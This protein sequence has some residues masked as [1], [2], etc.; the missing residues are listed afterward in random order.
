MLAGEEG[1][2]RG[3]DDAGGFDVGSGGAEAGGEGGGDPVAALAGV[4]TH[5]DADVVAEGGGEGDADCVDGALV[6]RGFTG[7]RSYS[8][9][10][11]QLPH[12]DP[13]DLMSNL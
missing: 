9:C 2:G 5:D 3:G 13:W 7:D 11:K 1:D 6:Q 4:H 8:V 10:A 12:A